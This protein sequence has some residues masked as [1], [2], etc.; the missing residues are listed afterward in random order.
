MDPE[1][2]V[3][4]ESWRPAAR[5]AIARLGSGLGAGFLCG[6]VIGG[7][8]G[9][10]A[11]LV[12]RLTSDPRLHGMQTDDDFIIGRFSGD[13][14]FLLGL[15]A[16]MGLAGGLFYLVVRSWIPERLRMAAMA[17]FG[18]T[19]GGALV[20]RDPDGVDFTLL[21]PLWLAIAMFVALPALY[22]VALSWLTERFLASAEPRAK[23]NLIVVLLPLLPVAA[24]GPIGIIVIVAL[25]SF[26]FVGWGLSRYLPLEAIWRS[27]AV[28][29]L[30]RA[31][32][33][34]LVALGTTN[35]LRNSIEILTGDGTIDVIK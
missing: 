12:L 5:V 8:G 3:S 19:V 21:E 10:L 17:V 7:V 27:P 30:G 9:R 26:W 16:V 32:L 14:I 11:M 13:T 24:L 1:E 18:A 6:V 35:L 34:W 23:R 33:A 15:T 31:A 20:I 25:L 29:W 22:G 4:G 28:T 2:N